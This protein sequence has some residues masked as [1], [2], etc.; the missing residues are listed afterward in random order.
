MNNGQIEPFLNKE[1]SYDE[2]MNTK[3]D[4]DLPHMASPQKHSVV[5]VGM[6]L[7]ISL[8]LYFVLCSYETPFL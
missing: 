6:W 3:S 7:L 5:V 2:T 8:K 4:G 1:G